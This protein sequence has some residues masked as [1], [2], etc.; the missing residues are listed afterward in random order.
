LYKGEVNELKQLLK[1]LNVER[2][3]KKKRDIIK[4]VIAYM[5]LGIDVS[6]LFTDMIMAVESKDIVV[7]KMVYL[8]LCNY[9]HKEPEMA[10]M[11]INSLRREC[12]NEDPMVRGLALRSLCNLRLESILEYIA[13]PLQK[14]LVDVSSYVRKTGVMSILKVYKLSPRLIE[15]NNYVLQ[16]YK[17]LQ[18][19][20][21]QVVTNVLMVLNEIQ[22]DQ[23]GVEISQTM[24]MHLLNRLGEFSEWGVNV[25]LDLVSRYQPASDDETFSIMNLLDPILRTASSSAVLATFKCFF[26]LAKSFPDIESQIYVRAKPPMLTL[27][28]GSH[29]EVQFVMLKHLQ[30]ILPRAAARGV[31]DDEYRQFFVRY[32]EP[33]HVKHLKIDLLPLI[34]ND[35]NAKDI[36]NELGEY[37]TDVDSELS[38]RAIAA[39]GNIA[40]HVSGVASD[41]TV[42]LIQLVDLDIPYVRA[43]TIKALTNIIRVYPDVRN[44][45][46]SS[47]VLSKCLRV[48][49]DSD[50]KA[51]IIWMLGE[52]GE[53]IVEAPYML[54]RVI[55]NY[56][57]EQAVSIKLQALSS[58]MKLLFKRPAEMQAMVGRLL[59][60]AINDSSNQD[61]H[62]RALLYY[63]LLSSNISICETLFK[64]QHN[65]NTGRLFAEENDS[66]TMNKLFNEFNTLAVIYGMPSVKFIAV[67]NQLKF[68]NAPMTDSIFNLKT[69]SVASVNATVVNSDSKNNVVVN[70]LDY[71]DDNSVSSHN[72]TVTSVVSNNLQLNQSYELTPPMFQS[73]WVALPDNFSGIIM[74]LPLLTPF[75]SSTTEVD[76]Y[77]KG[78]GIKTI[79]SGPFGNSGMKFFVAGAEISNNNLFLA[80]ILLNN[81]TKEVSIT[82]KIQGNS[83]GQE[84]I[85]LVKLCLANHK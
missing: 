66:E 67:E 70:L 19:A 36:A 18:D 71:D 38:K 5:T 24:I 14:S 9:A 10:I 12:E 23:G 73:L 39:I 57:D 68:E 62:D 84:F 61:L 6:R 82:L 2:D 43:E 50:A 47:H 51:C 41:M 28:T 20:D 17:M 3:V 42:T 44:H 58:A 16:L 26:Q 60:S 76:S 25:I 55:N 52:Y 33:A 79:A 29:S 85:D 54:E 81:E 30:I 27:I 31:F 63:R 37:V 77:F 69:I 45:V 34:S 75:P 65:T 72:A 32:N 59:C 11:C 13:Q 21:S 74:H 1:N 78:Y 15:T 83:T 7:K 4:K 80:Q 56:D 53:E 8:Y 22:L 48:V 46:I 64:G 49:E 40:T 35:N